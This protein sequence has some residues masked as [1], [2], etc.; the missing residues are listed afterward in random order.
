MEFLLNKISKIFLEIWEAFNPA[1]S[2]ILFGVSCS[3]NLSGK[4]ID[5]NFK[6]LSN[7]PFSASK[8]LTCEPNPPIEPSSIESKNSCS[9]AHLIIN[10]SSKGLANLASTIV[11]ETP[12]CFKC[13]AASLHSSSLVP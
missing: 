9:L 11:V 5:L 12:F 4:F 13:S 3:I 10:S 2:Y 7:I 8:F 6:P 1:V